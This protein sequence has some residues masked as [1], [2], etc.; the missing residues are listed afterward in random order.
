MLTIVFVTAFVLVFLNV[1]RL[2]GRHLEERWARKTLHSKT[3]RELARKM[4]VSNAESLL[5]ACRAGYT[6]ENL[7]RLRKVF[8]EEGIAPEEIGTTPEEIDDLGHKVILD[9]W[10]SLPEQQSFSEFREREG[11]LPI[12]P[13][14]PGQLLRILSLAD[15]GTGDWHNVEFREESGEILF[16]D[17]LEKETERNSDSFAR[18]AQTWWSIKRLPIPRD[19]TRRWG[20]GWN[21][22]HL[23]RELLLRLAGKE[24]QAGISIEW[25]GQA[26]IVTMIQFGSH[27]GMPMPKVGCRI[28]E[29]FRLLEVI[30]V[31]AL[32]IDVS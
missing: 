23:P 11:T 8:T 20:G 25:E 26:W 32:Y 31:D 19:A 2:L 21:D 12:K 6:F 1:L 16:P 28:E 10:E 9:E 29:N 15:M 5:R 22:T 24:Y 18:L 30:L 4:G 3:F 7:P 14:Y 27:S 17:D 13:P